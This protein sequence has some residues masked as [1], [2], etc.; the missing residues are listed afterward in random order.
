MAGARGWSRSAV[1]AFVCLWL[2]AKHLSTQSTAAVSFLVFTPAAISPSTSQLLIEAEM[3]GAPSRVN[4]DFNP[5]G[6]VNTVVALRDDG[7]E[8]D[9]HAG[10]RTWT[11]RL[12]A[13]PILAARQPD[14]AFRVFIGYLN[15][16]NGESR[17]LRGNLFVDVHTP[18]IGDYPVTRL[19]QFVQTTTRLVNIHH[20]TVFTNRNIATV[21]RDFY[22]DFPD[23]YD[24]VNII[25]SPQRFENRTH[26]VVKNAVGGIGLAI[27]D[28]SGN[29]GSAGRLIGISQFPIP[30]FYDGAATGFLHEL[31]HQWVNHMRV[32]PFATGVPHW[33]Y[34]SMA[35]GI[36]GFSIGGTGG[37]GGH[38]LCEILE[39]PRGFILN[40]RPA[41]APGYND[42]DLYLMGLLP[43]DQVR[44]QFV[45][46]DQTTPPRCDG[47]VYSGAMT[48]VRVNDVVAALGPRTPAFGEAP[49]TFRTATI[50]VTRDAL[51]TAEQMSFY[52]WMTE[53]AEWRARVSTHEG[54][55]KELGQPFSV[56]TRGRG[57]LRVDIDLGRPDFSVT[58]T[59]A[60][61][62]VVA[63]LRGSFDAPIRLTCEMLP[64]NASCTF[65]PPVVTPGAETRTV[66]LTV[67]TSGVAPGTYA[68]MVR[69]RSGSEQHSTAV[70]ISVGSSQ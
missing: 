49:T 56:A 40:A 53:R 18:E 7:A 65:D 26:G 50:L 61:E 62:I 67:A 39:D 36:M 6:T 57:T 32:T 48:R 31:G 9:R 69:G 8:G 46:P 14:D 64:A 59:S 27:S 15:L 38:F 34:S 11:A 43:A 28:S 23:D 19:S 30:G 60:S 66:R 55:S 21:L 1:V 5:A 4:V 45:F 58:A 2:S 52:S 68:V 29:Y 16:F 25:Y 47:S 24:V 22:R 3:A 35:T 63:P 44:D 41:G 70:S 10:D 33:P 54:F 20:A 51:A 17:T 42:L 13:A 37:Q 12:P